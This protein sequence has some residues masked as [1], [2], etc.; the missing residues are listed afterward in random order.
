MHIFNRNIITNIFTI[1]ST[2]WFL[3]TSVLDS[4]VSLNKNGSSVWLITYD[5]GL[6]LRRLLT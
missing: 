6:S 1:F 4:V 2:L 3:P 5:Q